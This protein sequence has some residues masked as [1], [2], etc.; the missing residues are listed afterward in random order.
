MKIIKKESKLCLSC[1]QVHEVWTVQVE[2]ESTFNQTKVK[3]VA[4]YE[5]CNITEEYIATEEMIIG[6]D[7]AMKDA[8]RKANGLLSSRDI[9]D[10]RRKYNIS[11]SDLATLLGWGKK[12]LTRYETHQVQD[13]AHNDIL[14]KIG[15]DPEWFL[16]LLERSREKVSERA[17]AKYA[18]AA[19]VLYAREANSYIKKAVLAQYAKEHMPPNA[20]GNTEP[21][22]NKLVEVINYIASS[23][24]TSLYLVKLIKMIWYSDALNYKRHGKSITGM[25]YK[26]LPMGAA[27][28]GYDQIVALQGVSYQ[29]V[30]FADGIGYLF[31][32]DQDFVPH[33]LSDDEKAS[34]D[35]VV[36]R[37][38]DASK[39]A[40]IKTMHEEEAYK[41]TEPYCIIS[42]DYAKQLSLS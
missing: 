21:D 14:V 7:I 8:Y 38:R 27:P 10:V 16:I 4:L 42:F 39:K 35:T 13:M 25:A 26:A 22:F 20:F 19:R 30:E 37:F 23:S 2:E 12:T 31:G 29:E 41:C 3:Y 34:I 5:Y 18:E 17:F 36:G 15:D 9:I 24:V 6:N 32:A 1:M 33:L 11:Q 28:I 40:I